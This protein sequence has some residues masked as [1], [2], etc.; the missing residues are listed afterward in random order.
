MWN[1]T[2]VD[3]IRQTFTPP[4][5]SA[6]ECDDACQA[7]IA[8]RRAIYLQSRTTT[9]RQEMFD[10]SRQRAALYNTTYRGASCVPGLP[11]L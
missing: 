9:S 11:C 8:E 4:P 3:A 10:L 5:A 6:A 7:R 1:I 2:R